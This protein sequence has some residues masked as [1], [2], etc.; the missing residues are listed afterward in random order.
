MMLRVNGTQHSYFR[1]G[2]TKC[3]SP[4]CHNAQCHFT[5]AT[6]LSIMT[7]SIATFSKITFSIKGLFVTL[8]INDTQSSIPISEKRLAK[9]HSPMCHN[10]QCHFTGATTLSIMTLSIT[11]FSKI[12]QY[13]GF[14][15]DTRY[16]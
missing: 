9:C 5:G 1:K 13:K 15:C 12:S 2:L 7:V 10:A 16:K 3:H 8:G 6:T 4:M 11:T 14:V